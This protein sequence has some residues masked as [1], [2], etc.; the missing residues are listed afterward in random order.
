MAR[1]V[2]MIGTRKGLWIATSDDD[3]AGRGRCRPRRAAQRG[4]CRRARHGEHRR[5]DRPRLFMA[6]KHWHWGP[7]VL[8]SDDLGA[9]WRER[10]RRRA[11]GFP[12]DTGAHVE[13]G[14]AARAR[15]R[16]SR[17][18]VGR[19]RA[20][21]AVPVR[22]TAAQ[23][24]DARA[25]AVGPPA[26]RAVGRR[27]R[28]PGLPHRAAA[29]RP[30]RSGDRRDVDRRRLP[31]RSTAAS[32]WAPRNQGIRAEFLPEGQQYPEFGQCVHK[33]ARAPGA[34][35]AAVRCRTTAA[36]T[37]PTT[38]A[39]SWTSIA[40]GLPSD[41]GFPIVVAP[42]RAGHRL[43]LPARRRRR[44][45]PARGRR[46]RLALQR[47]RRDLGGAAASGLPDGF[48][49]GVMRD[50][51]CVDD[52]RRRPGSTSA[53][54]TARVWGCVDAGD[55]LARRSSATCPT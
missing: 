17:R 35:R 18:G 15:R 50:A 52:A 55:D 20:V 16:A 46:A 33:V 3:S 12:E 42:A 40:D 38:R 14:L 45:L 48:F 37:A 1:T 34:T 8:R 10:P 27:L 36:S 4:A 21:G 9:T 7:Q 23:T 26:P 49:V 29:P 13:R 5:P 24:F 30:T 44:A 32:S 51:M 22:P 19:H 6:S 2:L 53:P 39:D 31:D 47:R 11:S 43:R 54:A 28:R 41:F 25:R